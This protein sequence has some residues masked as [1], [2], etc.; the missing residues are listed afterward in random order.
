MMATKT[1]EQLKTTV[2]LAFSGVEY[3][4]DWC[5]SGSNEGEEPVLLKEAFK[6]KKEWESLE[7]H[8]LDSAPNGFASALS[9][10]S[11]EAFHFYLQAYLIADIDSKLKETD[12]VYYLTHGL[13][14]DSKNE[15]INPK[16]YGERTWWDAA[17][18]KFS[19]FNQKECQ[20]IVAYLEFKMENGDKFD[21]PRIKEALENYWYERA[22][23]KM[24]HKAA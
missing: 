1:K 10:F 17:L 18:Y 12:P 13:S 6:G 21:N 14:A 16:R 15:R 5:L 2:K 19:I 8:F 11:A 22:G 4:G 3:P 23:Q 9:F 7:P 20:A 24:S